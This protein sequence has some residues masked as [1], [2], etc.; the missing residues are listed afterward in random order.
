M[1]NVTLFIIPALIWGSTWLVI[2]FQLGVVDPLISIFYRF[3]LAS[4]ILLIFGKMKGM[5]LKY[6]FKQHLILV[7]L[8]LLL[9][10]INYWLVYIA[11]MRLTSGLVAVVF[12]TII[13]FNIF[14]TGLFLKTKITIRVILGAILGFTGVTLV[15][16]DDLLGF[17]P[18]SDTSWAFALA[19][20]GAVSASLGNITSA[21]SQAKKIPVIPGTAYGMLYGSVSMLIVGLITGNTIDFDSSFAYTGSLLYLVIFGSMIGFGAYL[22]LIG[23]IGAHRAGYVTL[24]IPVIAMIFSTIFE[25]YRWNYYA[26]GGV[27]LILSG[28]AFVLQKSNMTLK[29]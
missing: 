13:F 6:S 19:L 12:S 23:R 1:Q 7:V 26:F 18:A 25:D 3:F 8:G 21:Y 5:N 14:F 9:F 20:L 27:L 16:K 4:V 2:K 15:F 28:I 29:T 24:V 22:T 17:S 10:G 11:E